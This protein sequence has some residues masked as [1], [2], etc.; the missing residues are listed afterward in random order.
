MAVYGVRIL[1]VTLPPVSSIQTA[2]N[3]DYRRRRP[4]QNANVLACGSCQKASPRSSKSPGLLAE[5]IQLI[6][7]IVGIHIM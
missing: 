3:I 5:T 7:G 4:K 6:S 2:R 1:A